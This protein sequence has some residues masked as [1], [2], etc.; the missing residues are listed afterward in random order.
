MLDIIL[1]CLLSF[2]STFGIIQ[3][4][5]LVLQDSSETYKKSHLILSLNNDDNIEKA[6][7]NALNHYLKIIVLDKNQFNSN[8]RYIIESFLNNHDNLFFMDINTYTNF[9]QDGE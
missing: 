7:R 5:R 1:W 2:F 4:I 6:I 9:L 8:S 3:L